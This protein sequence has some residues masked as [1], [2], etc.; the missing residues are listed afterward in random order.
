MWHNLQTKMQI[1]KNDEWG[2][3]WGVMPIKNKGNTPLS[4]SEICRNFSNIRY[5]K[6]VFHH[7]AEVHLCFPFSCLSSRF[8]LS[9]FMHRGFPAVIQ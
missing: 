5:G 3:E 8:R 2:V 9:N 1:L 6:K 7:C 4:M